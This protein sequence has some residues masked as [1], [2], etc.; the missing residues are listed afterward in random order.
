MKDVLSQTANVHPLKSLVQSGVAIKMLVGDHAEVTKIMDKVHTTNKEF[1]RPNDDN[2]LSA[3]P[4]GVL[5]DLDEMLLKR[6]RQDYED[7]L[8]Q[9]KKN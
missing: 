8:K 7:S 6:I 3:R 1:L 4:A 9:P 2:G 5:E